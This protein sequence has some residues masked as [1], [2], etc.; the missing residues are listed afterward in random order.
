MSQTTLLALQ[1]PKQS[2]TTH[3]HEGAAGD[4]QSKARP[5]A[6]STGTTL[7]PS[8]VNVSYNITELLLIIIS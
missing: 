4:R 8:T 6:V 2:S 1:R 7:L 3:S 5:S